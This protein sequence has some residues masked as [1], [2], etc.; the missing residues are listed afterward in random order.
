MEGVCDA[1]EGGST[2]ITEYFAKGTVP[3][4]YCNCHVKATLCLDTGLLA[5]DYCT[6]VEEKIL[7]IKDEPKIYIPTKE[8]LSTAP[9]EDPATSKKKQYSYTTS[10]TKYILPSDFCNVHTFVEVA[11]IEPEPFTPDTTLPT[12]TTPID[13]VNP[14]STDNG[15]Q[16]H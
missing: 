12:P 9:P 4:A 6:N 10:D 3:T 8:D 1:Y 16:S 11:P 7:L 15:F 14:Y 5:S 13:I 2:V